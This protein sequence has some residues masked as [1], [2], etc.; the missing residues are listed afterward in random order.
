M[1]VGVEVE[2][3]VVQLVETPA[4][5]LDVAVAVVFGP[6]RGGGH[7]GDDPAQ[8]AEVGVER[9][10]EDLAGLVRACCREVVSEPIDPAGGIAGEINGPS[11]FVQWCSL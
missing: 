11:G 5:R 8:D 4:V 10:M 7:E 3:E 9:G 2:D 1:Q 6:V